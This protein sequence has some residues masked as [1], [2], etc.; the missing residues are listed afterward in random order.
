MA[1]VLGIGHLSNKKVLNQ[2]PFGHMT[3]TRILE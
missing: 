1:K 2:G 3:R